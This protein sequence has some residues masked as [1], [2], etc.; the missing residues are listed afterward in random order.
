MLTTADLLPAG[1][2]QVLHA[3]AL[4]GGASVVQLLLEAGADPAAPNGAGETAL[5]LAVLVGQWECAED[6]VRSPRGAGVV[7]VAALSPCDTRS[8]PWPQTRSPARPPQVS[9]H[10]R[11]LVPPLAP[12]ASRTPLSESPGPPSAYN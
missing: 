7:Q 10:P 11:P 1:R 9:S 5:S 4:S 12:Y 8:E 2:P 3:A 6:L